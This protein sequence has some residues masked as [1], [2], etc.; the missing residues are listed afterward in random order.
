MGVRM[1]MCRGCVCVVDVYVCARVY[2]PVRCG[3]VRVRVH[4]CMRACVR[5]CVR[6][7]MRACV[8]VCVRVYL[9]V[10]VVHVCVYVC[11]SVC[12]YLRVGCR[13]AHVRVH[14]CMCPGCL[15]ARIPPL[16]MRLMA[17]ALRKGSAGSKAIAPLCST[18]IEHV[19]TW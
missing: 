13:C 10:R 4:M 2:L 14:M 7:C 12:V 17:L 5:A 19:T 9:C 15:C 3:C 16:P 11:V 18:P 1:W 8:Y 6:A